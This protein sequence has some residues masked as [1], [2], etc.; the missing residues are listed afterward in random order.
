M[1]E[2]KDKLVLGLETGLGGGSV[3]ILRNGKQVDFAAGSENVSR[4]ED[5]LLLIGELLEKNG[6]NKREIGRIAVSAAPGS[7]TGLRIG[8]ALAKGL[9]DSL[10]AEVSKMSLLEALISCAELKGSVI[11]AIYVENSG[12]FYGFF[13]DAAETFEKEGQILQTKDEADFLRVLRFRADQGL[14]IVLNKGFEKI[15]RNSNRNEFPGEFMNSVILIDG[16]FAEVLGKAALQ[17]RV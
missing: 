15:L 14:S 12:I 3:S 4:S 17:K 2:A 6:L 16:N 11:S 9:G 7:L 5:L 8:L 10:S 1:P 13:Q